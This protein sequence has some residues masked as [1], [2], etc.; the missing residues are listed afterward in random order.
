MV[1]SK[2]VPYRVPFVQISNFFKANFF[3]KKLWFL[4]FEIFFVVFV[5]RFLFFCFHLS[6]HLSTFTAFILHL[7]L[8]VFVLEA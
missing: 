3:L 6:F 2:T 4:F 5:F 7:C 1:Y 8:R